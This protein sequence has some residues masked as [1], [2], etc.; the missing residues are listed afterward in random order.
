MP[1]SSTSSRLSSLER[2]ARAV[3][4]GASGGIGSAV[5]GLLAS[6]GFEAVHAL[7]R[8]GADRSQ[9]GGVRVGRIDI[10][11]EVSIAAA[12]EQ[13]TDG[14]PLRLI[15]VA[16]GLLHDA[17]L[18]PEK[19]YRALNPEQLARS[20]HINDTAGERTRIFNPPVAG[21]TGRPMIDRGGE[22]PM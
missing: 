8:S 12:A 10:E 15:L 20:F 13:L 4:I 17:T 7:S 5:T 21:E 2:P 11:D 1:Q 16:T 9:A 18:Q 3:V 6:E 19:T 22:R 14:A